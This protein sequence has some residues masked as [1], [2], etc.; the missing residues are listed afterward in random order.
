MKGW[1]TLLCCLTI[2]SVF[3]VPAAQAI[4]AFARREGA[5]CQMCHFG[6]KTPTAEGE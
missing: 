6:N 3:D 2:A 1:L 5:K 4:P